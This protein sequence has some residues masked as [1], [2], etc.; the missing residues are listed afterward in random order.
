MNIT[1]SQVMGMLLQPC[2]QLLWQQ[3]T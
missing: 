2:D 3:T 1:Y